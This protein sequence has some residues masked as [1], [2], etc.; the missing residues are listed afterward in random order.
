M[1]ERKPWTDFHFLNSAFRDTVDFQRTKWIN[2]SLVRLTYRALSSS[3][4]SSAARQSVRGVAGL[5]VE[6]AAP[7][8]LYYIFDQPCIQAYN[9]IFVLLVQLRRAKTVLDGI[10]VR[11]GNATGLRPSESKVLYATRGR[12]SWVVK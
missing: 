7:F 11:R 2:S 6:Y 12:L 8:P 1:D 4:G 9:E 5:C 10:L 3:P